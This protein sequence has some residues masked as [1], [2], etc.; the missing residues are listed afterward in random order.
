M[1]EI[2]PADLR[3]LSYK[4]PIQD[5]LIAWRPFLEGDL[6]A[7]AREAALFVAHCMRDPEYVKEIAEVAGQQSIYP[8]GW[9]PTDLAS[10]DAGL[11]LMYS[12]VD[13]CFPGQ[14]FDALNQQ[15]LRIAAEGTR[16]AT[17][18]FPALF[19]GTAGLAFTLSAS[20]QGGSCYQRTLASVHEGLSEQVITLAWRRSE[21]EGGISSSDFDLI[22][23]AAGILAYLV[24]IEQ[25]SAAIQ[26]AIVHLLMST[27]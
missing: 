13:A 2:E 4:N 1:Q 9:S 26:K 10:G 27:A 25:A 17:L 8:V 19:G 11:A 12:Y 23:G 21:A 14:G 7:R 5:T 24:S 15:Y 3:H 22:S 6:R 18:L 16:Q 20:S